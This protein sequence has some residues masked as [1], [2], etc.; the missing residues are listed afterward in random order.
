M[1]AGIAN[2]GSQNITV[3]NTP[4]SEA[5]LKVQA[6]GTIFFD[7]SNSDYT[8]TAGGPGVSVAESG[9]STNVSETG[10]IDTYELSLQTVPSAAVEITVSAD[11]QSEV[12]VDGVNFVST[13][14]FSRTDTTAQTVTVRAV[15]DN[16]QEGNHTSTISHAITNS[17]DTTDYPTLS[18]IHI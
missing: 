16:S 15:D 18:L 6:V 11:A 13:V 14:V 1:A 9:G 17:G 2:D 4:T 8:I 5:R 7:I 10:G 12:S 3:P